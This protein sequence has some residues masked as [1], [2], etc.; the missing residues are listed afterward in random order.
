[1]DSARMCPGLALCDSYC[2]FVRLA[3]QPTHNT[4]THTPILTAG[5]STHTPYLKTQQEALSDLPKNAKAITLVGRVLAHLPEG[6]DKAKRAFQK[7]LA[8][9]PLTVDAAAALAELYMGQGE[10]E[11]CVELLRG[12]LDHAAHDFL[13]AKLGEVMCVYVHVRVC[14]L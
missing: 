6:R 1:L 8:I 14:C 13:W 5:P 4:P 9:D 10:Y 2:S 3:V 11:P 12:S 7:A